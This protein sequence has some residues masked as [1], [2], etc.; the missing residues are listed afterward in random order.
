M[1]DHLSQLD[2]ATDRFARLLAEGDLDALVPPC[3]GWRLADLGAHLGEIHQWAEHAVVAGNPDAVLSP[4]PSDRAGLVEWYR[5]SAQTLLG[6]LQRTDP[7]TPVWSFGPKPRTAA[8]WFRRQ[9]HETT[10]HLWDAVAS[11]GERLPVD[12]ELAEDGIDE[13]LTVFFPRQVRL[14]R[15][16]ALEHSLALA[17]D[18]RRWVLARSGLGSVDGPADP[19]E[20]TAEATVS[21]PAEAL[22]LLVWGRIGL[23]DP[24]LSLTGDHDAALAVLSAGLTP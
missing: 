18:D 3:P 1:P 14:G 12:G 22:L 23:D 9:A 7:A 5:Q 17:T 13:V 10:L 19:P 6:T 24:R 15:I 20:A 21:G 2:H 16:P 11:Q 4:A 8:F